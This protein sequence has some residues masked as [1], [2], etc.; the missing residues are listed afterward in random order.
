M[1][2]A[3]EIDAYQY[4]PPKTTQQRVDAMRDE[5]IR[6]ALQMIKDGKSHDQIVS[7]LL[8]SLHGQVQLLNTDASLALS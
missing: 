4:H 1:N 2:I 8:I 7:L 5:D 6:I 3:D